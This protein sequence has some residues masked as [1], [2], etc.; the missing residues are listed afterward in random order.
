MK[1]TQGGKG[2]SSEGGSGAN[3]QELRTCTTMP[4]RLLRD[5][6]LLTGQSPNHSTSYNAIVDELEKI[7]YDTAEVMDEL[8]TIVLE[9]MHKVNIPIL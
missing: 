2:R 1:Q 3:H 7:Q 6:L 9:T 5:S 4:K 8:S